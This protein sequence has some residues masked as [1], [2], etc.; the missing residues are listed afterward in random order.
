MKKTS[1]TLLFILIFLMG[2]CS[3]PNPALYKDNNVETIKNWSFQFNEET[4]DY[5]IFWR[6]IFGFS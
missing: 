4:N 6:R 1:C 5:S 3:V 2:G